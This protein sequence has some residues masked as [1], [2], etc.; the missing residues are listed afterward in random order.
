MIKRSPPKRVFINENPF[1]CRDGVNENDLLLVEAMLQKSQADS[2]SPQMILTAGPPG[3][4]KTTILK[5]HLDSINRKHEEF[6]IISVDDLMEMIP[7]YQKAIDILKYKPDYGVKINQNQKLS[8]RRAADDCRNLARALTRD[9]LLPRILREKRDFIY[10]T[11]ARNTRFY[12]RLIDDAKKLGY[13]VTTLYVT[14]SLDTLRDRVSGRSMKTGRYIPLNTVK[15]ISDT[16]KTRRVFESL[17]RLSDRCFAYDN[18]RKQILLA[19]K[20]YDGVLRCYVDNDLVSKD[21]CDQ[22]YDKK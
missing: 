17:C 7:E 19:E 3:A 6:A 22:H 18:E 8:S 12:E 5:H 2:T 11:T 13:H 21:D 14:A 1:P 10:D 4:G 9:H 15:F 16:M 20:D